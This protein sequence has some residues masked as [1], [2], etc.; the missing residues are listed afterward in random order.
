MENRKI[1]VSY[2]PAKG[3]KE[4]TGGRAVPGVI[5]TAFVLGEPD[6]TKLVTQ[7]MLTK[8]QSSDDYTPGTSPDMDNAALL[9]AFVEEASTGPGAKAEGEPT[10]AQWQGALPGASAL[11]KLKAEGG[12]ETGQYEAFLGSGTTR[13]SVIGTL[14]TLPPGGSLDSLKAQLDEFAKSIRPL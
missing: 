9:D 8:M 4:V 2:V 10:R 1:G 14:T 5:T 6:P 3:F 13:W 11:V 7:F 12:E